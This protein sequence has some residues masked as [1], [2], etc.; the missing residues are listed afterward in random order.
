M[1][2]LI[3]WDYT[4]ECSITKNYVWFQAQTLRD[5]GGTVLANACGP[6]IGQWDRKDVKKGEK[7]TIVSSY[8]RNFTGRNDANPATHAFVTSPELVTALAIAG[9]LDFNPIT[10]K[11]KSAD[12]EWG[13]PPKLFTW[14][15][16][17]NNITT[18]FSNLTG[19]SSPS[20]F[21]Y[22]CDIKF[23]QTS[24]VVTGLM[25]KI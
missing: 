14:W 10:N 12:G 23:V 16:I 13:L 4:V 15:Q 3:C 8:N 1:L 9:T 17:C 2:F 24:I 25:L 11:L 20:A 6:C 22:L 18:P 5:F 19:I 21:S 7:N